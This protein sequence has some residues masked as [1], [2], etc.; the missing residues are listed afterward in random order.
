LL[1]VHGSFV[2]AFVLT[3]SM[4]RGRKKVDEEAH[5]GSFV[6][7]GVGHTEAEYFARSTHLAVVNE[8]RPV[9]DTKCRGWLLTTLTYN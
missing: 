2:L 9:I 7:V 8:C 5:W 6:N 4:A 3:A 1:W